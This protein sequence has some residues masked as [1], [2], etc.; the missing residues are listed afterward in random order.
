MQ[1]RVLDA[2]IS[3]PPACSSTPTLWQWRLPQVSSFISVADFAPIRPEVRHPCA[4]Q[5]NTTPPTTDQ[6]R[7]APSL[8]APSSP[9]RPRWAHHLSRPGQ[10]R[11]STAAAMVSPHCYLPRQGQQV[12]LTHHALAMAYV[13]HAVHDPTFMH[14]EHPLT[15]TQPTPNWQQRTCS[16]YLPFQPTNPGTS[17]CQTYM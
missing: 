2:P 10:A 1:T 3:P 6:A 8:P 7:G 15:L 9:R 12:L 13:A 17:C 4:T 5:H 11:P 16:S 14:S